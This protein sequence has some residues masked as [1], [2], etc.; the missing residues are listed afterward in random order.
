[1]FNGTHYEGRLCAFLMQDVPN[2]AG[3]LGLL[4][5]FCGY[6]ERVFINT[7]DDQVAKKQQDPLHDLARKYILESWEMSEKA[8]AATLEP[9]GW[10]VNAYYLVVVL[11]I[12]DEKE[13]DYSS[14]YL[15][16]HLESGMPQSCA[17]AN[18][19]YII[20]VVAISD[21]AERRIK[22]E[23]KLRKLLTYVV[24]EFNCKAGLSGPLNSFLELRNGYAKARAALRIGEKKD[25]QQWVFLFSDYVLDY[26]LDRAGG[27]LPV[28]CLIHPALLVLRDQ[29]SRLGTSYVKTI[30]Q[31]MDARYNVSEAAEKL[32]VHRTTLI[33][34][35]EKIEELTGITFENP[36]ELLHLGLSL[37]L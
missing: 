11:K 12:A 35:L 13:F 21:T 17:I 27:E 2:A 29:D 33:R 19:P 31:F 4:A 3:L 20:W 6:V 25:P 16:R 34:R 23:E 9:I 7:A 26:V 30:R 5:H 18:A 28:D 8:I 36:R 14:L 24:R 22:N 1:M 10:Q 32:Y 37:E 15:C